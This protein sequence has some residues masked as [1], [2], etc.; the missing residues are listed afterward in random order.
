[1][2]LPLHHAFLAVSCLKIDHQLS[3][4]F[5]SRLNAS[6]GPFWEAISFAAS[7]TLMF[8]T[9]VL[10]VLLLAGK[11][12]WQ[13]LVTLVLTVPCGILLGEGLKLIVRRQRPYLVG[14]FVNW[15]GYS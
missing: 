3:T 6:T 10:S 4:W 2:V 13:S 15:S 9:L 5:H 1:M 8:V 14:P 11:R 12:R 7:G